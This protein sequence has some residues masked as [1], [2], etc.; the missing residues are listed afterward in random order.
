MLR[1]KDYRRLI[2][3]DFSNFYHTITVSMEIYIVI[4]SKYF[5]ENLFYW[6]DNKS[7]V[8]DESN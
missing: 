2:E 8:I 4:V 5:K 6:I 1:L 3:T 7:V